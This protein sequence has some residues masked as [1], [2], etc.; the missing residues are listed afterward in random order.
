MPS[1]PWP[2]HVSHSAGLSS[3][4]EADAGRGHLEEIF[5]PLPAGRPGLTHDAMAVHLEDIERGEGHGAPRPMARLEDGLDAL[6]AVA[7]DR[8]A[9][10]DGRRDGPAE[11]AQP[12]EPRQ[13]DQLAAGS[14]EGVD[15][16][17]VPHMEV[18]ALAVQLW[19]RAVARSASRRG[20]SRRVAS[21][22]GM[23]GMAAPLS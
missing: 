8:L 21:I 10:E 14:A 23:K 12:G 18:G 6:A 16:T 19:L 11:L 2:T 1:P 9:I 5:E 15:G 20:S 3:P 22:G 4:A 13:R 7:G 17:M